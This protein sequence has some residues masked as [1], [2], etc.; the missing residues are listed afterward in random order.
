MMKNI[1]IISI[2]IILITGC[3]GPTTQRPDPNDATVAIEAAKQREIAFREQYK[4][5]ERLKRVGW[6]ILKAG[7]P[8]CIDRKHNAI[9]L[10]FANK[11]DYDNEL[12]DVAISTYGLG[13]VLQ[14]MYVIENTPAADV[15]LMK[16]DYL[17]SINKVEIPTGEGASK[18][19]IDKILGLTK[20]NADITLQI[21][22]GG[23][24]ETIIVRTEEICGYPLIV[25][26]DDRVNAFANGNSIII[27]Q[28]MMDFAETDDELAIVIAHELAH[29]NMRHI[30]AKQINAFAGLFV[31][32]LISV[33][34]GV[35]TQGV[36]SEVGARAYSQGFEAEADYVGL[37]TTE[38]AGYNIDGAPYFWRK[39]GVKHPASINQNHAASHPSTPE[40]FVAIEDTI[41]EINQ[42]KIAGLQLMPNINEENRSKGDAPPASKLSFSP[43]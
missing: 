13:E 5:Q 3:V 16:G 9:G 25:A 36:F 10:F 17:I 31:D 39:M 11:Y 28:G 21:Q 42:K 7:T 26:I 1:F 23:V 35:N 27:N 12:R 4:Y 32:L 24:T 40:R 22:R 8:L 34:T 33:L 43:N 14:I 30:D 29:N 41:K 2:L 15:G 37:Y 20:Q 18:K 19:L 38:L 6:P